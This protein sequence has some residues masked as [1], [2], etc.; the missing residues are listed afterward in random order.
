MRRA[1][2]LIAVSQATGRDIVRLLGIPQRRISVVYEGVDHALFRPGGPR[3]L[4]DPY[5]LYVGSEHPRKNLELL[6]HA[7]AL[8]KA[9]G[10]FPRL[11]LLKVG[12]AGGGEAPFRART[13]ALLRSFGVGADV[14]FTERVLESELPNLYSHAECF[15]YPSRYEG[16]GLPPLEAM[17]CGCPVIVSDA[18]ALVE[19]SGPG[20]FVCPRDDPSALARLLERLLRDR[21]LRA[22]TA[23]R[24]RLHAE[25]FSWQRSAEATL[26]VYRL[27][28]A[29][30]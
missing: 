26:A 2:R 1:A 4:A 15:V 8:L 13:L 30:A 27:A 24:G 21:D 20:A 3:P 18:D 16:F 12:P 29:G 11:R 17:S 23:E 14:V 19:V 7:F 9:G 22:E 5:L 6:L 10:R 25:A 28:A